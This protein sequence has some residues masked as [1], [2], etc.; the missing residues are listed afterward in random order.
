M[1]LTFAHASEIRLEHVQIS[2]SLHF[3]FFSLLFFLF[4]FC[5][6]AK[7]RNFLFS[8]SINTI[9]K[10]MTNKLCIFLY[11][12]KFFK[13]RKEEACKKPTTTITTRGEN[14][15]NN[16]C[17]DIKKFS[18]DFEGNLFIYLNR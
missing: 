11:V 4:F 18:Q 9:S 8:F 7:A 2:H 3:S 16:F 5:F 6:S 14:D 10:H 17:N 12:K 15:P 1:N 13:A